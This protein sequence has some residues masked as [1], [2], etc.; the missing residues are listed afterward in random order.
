MKYLLDTHALIWIVA[1]SKRLSRGIRQITE[2]HPAA[3]FA[4]SA[5]TLLEVAR[6]AKAGN[7]SLGD[8][9]E[10]WLE[11]VTQ[12]FE[13]LPITP[14]IAWKSVSFDWAHKDPADRLICATV[15]EHKLT[16][17]THDREIT[18]W[19]GVPVLW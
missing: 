15:L 17:I 5:I 1:D 3:D 9:P 12:R 6:L 14:A 18:R 16:L 10:Q 19:K 11:D 8:R 2:S 7:V 4:L 13:V